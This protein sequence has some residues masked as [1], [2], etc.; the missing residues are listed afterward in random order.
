M[1][2]TW[3]RLHNKM[4]KSP[5]SLT[6]SSARLP[7]WTKLVS[8]KPCGSD[9]FGAS[10][11]RE[12]AQDAEGVVEVHDVWRAGLGWGADS[13]RGRWRRGVLVRRF[14]RGAEYGFGY[15]LT[16]SS[17]VKM[18]RNASVCENADLR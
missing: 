6:R 15:D 8:G 5:R 10:G 18:R 13:R 2:R 17:R 12:G 16:A 11:N 7:P 4:S 14:L 3:Q 9:F 1:R